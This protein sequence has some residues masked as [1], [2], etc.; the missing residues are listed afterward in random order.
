M[1]SKIIPTL[2]TLICY[3]SYFTFRS[4]WF[5]NSVWRPAVMNYVCLCSSEESLKSTPEIVRDCVVCFFPFGDTICAVGKYCYM[6]NESPETNFCCICEV[7]HCRLGRIIILQLSEILSQNHSISPSGNCYV[8]S[9]N[10]ISGTW[11]TFTFPDRI[12]R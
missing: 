9:L 1:Q 5:Q 4:S 8:A 7:N 6:T 10:F 3:P 2:V 11:A 12:L